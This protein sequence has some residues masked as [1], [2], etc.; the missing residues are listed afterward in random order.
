MR[1]LYI[2]VATAAALVA[3]GAFARSP[4]GA[5][6]GA[7]GLP[8]YGAPSLQL[9][10]GWENGEAVDVGTFVDLLAHATPWRRRQCWP[11]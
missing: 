11:G 9:T 10:E 8:A 4:V 2:L 7:V 5:T 6:L 1:S 3:P